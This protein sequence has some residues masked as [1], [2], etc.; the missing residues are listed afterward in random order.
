MDGEAA[1]ENQ[2]V[3]GEAGGVKRAEPAVTSDG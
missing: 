2:S 3:P 1:E